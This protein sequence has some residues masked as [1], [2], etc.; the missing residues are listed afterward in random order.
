MNQAFLVFGLKCRTMI[1]LNMELFIINQD[2]PVF[3]RQG[4]GSHHFDGFIIMKT[5]FFPIAAL[6]IFS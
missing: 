5:I 3:S 6:S 1:S 2:K 4:V